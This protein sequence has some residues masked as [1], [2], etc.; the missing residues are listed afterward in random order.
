MSITAVVDNT[1]GSVTL[2]LDFTSSPTATGFSVPVSLTRT[3]PDGVV[4]AVRGSPAYLAA[5]LA[6]F[7]DTEIPANTLVTYTAQAPLVTGT[8]LTL[9]GVTVTGTGQQLGGFLK[10]PI[11]GVN[12]LTLIPVTPLRTG[13][14]T[15]TGIGLLSISEYTY[16][17]ASGVFDIIGDP[18]PR[19]ISQVRKDARGTISLQTTQLSDITALKK[20]LAT[21]RPLLLQLST[22]FGWAIDRYGSDYIQVGDVSEGRLELPDLRHT[23]RIWTLPFTLVYAPENSPTLQ[24]GGNNTGLRGASWQTLKDAGTTWSILVG[25]MTLDAF[26]GAAASGWGAA[27]VGGTWTTEG[28]VAGDYSVTPPAGQHSM[29][30]TSARKTTLLTSTGADTDQYI[31][32]YSPVLAAGAPIELSLMARHT[33]GNNLYYGGAQINTNQTITALIVKRV[34]GVQTTVASTTVSGLTHAANLPINLRLRVQGTSL[35]LKVWRGDTAQPTSWTIDTTDAALTTAG[36]VGVSSVLNSGNTNTLP[37]VSSFRMYR[38]LNL[39]TA[40]TWLVLAQGG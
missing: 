18:R 9:T 30:T 8:V 22:A 16:A 10:D 14:E 28:G 21:G 19:I 29:G 25:P 39:A 3:T 26:G 37:V 6:L 11:S 35:R 34:A 13:C 33:D 12:D 20:L 36:Q 40:K 7:V 2:T 15:V 38:G 17:T 27:D 23:Q 4:T 24:Y 5:G 31:T 1:Y 32:A